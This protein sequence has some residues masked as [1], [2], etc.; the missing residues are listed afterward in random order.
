MGKVR[1]YDLAKELKVDSDLV[2][3]AARRE[4][5]DVSIPSNTISHEVA[6]KIRR[7]LVPPEKAA[8]RDARNAQIEQIIKSSEKA[9]R[10][11]HDD[12]ETA[13]LHA[14]KASEAICERI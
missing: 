9:V 1:L 5:I 3:D 12:P 4:G 14:R 2:I 13:L 7:T 11:S 8:L 10:Y 6:D